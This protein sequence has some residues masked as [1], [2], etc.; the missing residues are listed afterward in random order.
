MKPWEILACA[1]T[2]H[3]DQFELLLHDGTYVIS[4][5]G[6][7]LMTSYSHGSEDAMMSLACPSPNGDACVLVGGLGMR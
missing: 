4:A 6:H 5:N 1:E 3:G 2:P 7:D